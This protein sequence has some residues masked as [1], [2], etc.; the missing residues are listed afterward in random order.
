MPQVTTLNTPAGSI[1]G[2]SRKDGGCEFL[3]IRFAH[4]DRL[5]PPRDITSWDGELDATKFGPICPQVPGMLESMLGFDGSN[6]SEDCLNLSVFT[7]NTPTGATKLPVLVWIHGG[8]FTN[9]SGSIPWYHGSALASRGAVVVSINY[10]LGAFGFLGT[11]NYGTLDM[12]S[13]LRWVQR[14]IAAFDGDANNVTIFGESAGGSA[15]VSLMSSRDAAGLFHKVWAMSPSIGQLRTLPRAQVLQTQFLELAEVSSLDEVRAM[16]LDEMLAVQ[17]KLMALPAAN[18]DFFTPTAGGE[19]L[20]FDILSAAAQSALPLVLGSNHDE[21]RL[22]SA[23]DPAQ[24][25]FGQSDWERVSGEV[26]GDRASDARAVYEKLR[27]T[28]TP[29]QLIS[30]VR[31]DTAFRQRAQRLAE[32]HANHSNPTWMYWFTW[33]TPAFGGILGSC[34]ALDIPF[35]FD[36]LSAPGTDMLTGDGGERAGIAKRFANEIVQ[37]ARTS[38]PTWDAFETTHRKTLEINAE[39]VVLDDPEK[40][41][42]EI[43]LSL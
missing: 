24:A 31:T 6:M 25:E 33:A 12:I 2:N 16:P 43:F 21:D 41:I 15:V 5:L 23:M 10:R 4:A 29:K 22:W 11:G 40:E 32:Q 36:N 13:A 18:F 28:E 14:N 9:G 20:P 42:R 30:S 1:R 17:A 27:P 39:F 8:A 35:A 26:F 37:F 34:H 7:H 38:S 19:A 3:G